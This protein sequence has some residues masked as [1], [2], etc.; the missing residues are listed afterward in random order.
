MENRN[1]SPEDCNDHIQ[2]VSAEDFVAGI[3]LSSEDLHQLIDFFL[4]LDRWEREL[5]QNGS[6]RDEVRVCRMQ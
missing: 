5:V 3:L 6:N 4:L 2:Q 1:V